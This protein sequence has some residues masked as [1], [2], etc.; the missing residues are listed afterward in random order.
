MTATEVHRKAMEHWDAAVIARHAGK[1]RTAKYHYAQAMTL[2]AKAARMCST[3][4]SRSVCFRS[5]AMFAI[6]AERFADAVALVDE[7]LLNNPPKSLADEL[8][9]VL[10]T[11]ECLLESAELDRLEAERLCAIS[12]EPSA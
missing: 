5:A 1:V 12:D 10:V 6:H 7:G 11:A 9:E 4:P 8:K 2:E 3:E